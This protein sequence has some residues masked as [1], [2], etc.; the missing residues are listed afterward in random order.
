MSALLTN[1]QAAARLGV[2]L[3]TL[4]TMI[5]EGQIRRVPW[6]KRWRFRE[7]DVEAAKAGR[8]HPTEVAASAETAK[9]AA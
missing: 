2:S 1:E 5:S 3:S 6:G 8:T 4:Y 9:E 7:E